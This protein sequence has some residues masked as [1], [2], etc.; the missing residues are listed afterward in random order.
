MSI[1]LLFWILMV[2]WGFF[3]GRALWPGQA[4]AAGNYYPFGAGLLL[5]ILIALLGIGQF[6]WPIRG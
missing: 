4:G 2:L 5:F 6:G 3:G 1:G